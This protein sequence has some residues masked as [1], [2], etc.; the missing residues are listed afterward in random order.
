MMMDN[1]DKSQ[2]DC[3][4]DEVN[5]LR[6][7]AHKVEDKLEQNDLFAIKHLMKIL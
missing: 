5:E 2:T 6:L 7:A 1:H 4:A 3:Y